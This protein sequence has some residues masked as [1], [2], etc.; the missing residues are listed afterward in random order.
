MPVFLPRQQC[1]RGISCCNS[2]SLSVSLSHACYVTKPNNAL[3]IFWYHC[4]F[5]AQTVV[6]GRRPLPSEICAQSNPSPPKCRLW[7]ITAHDVST[8][9]DSRKNSVMTNRKSTTSYRWSAH[10]SPKSP[11][12]WLEKHL[13]NKIQFQSNKVCYK[14]SMCENFQRKSCSITIFPSNG[15]QMLARNV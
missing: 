6:G 1:Q 13:K 3:R 12:A 5:L 9:R 8:V 4:S 14:V 15:P 10:V 7:Q 2:V 11:K